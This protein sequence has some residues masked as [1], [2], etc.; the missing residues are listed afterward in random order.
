MQFEIIFQFNHMR[1]VWGQTLSV[2]KYGFT[3]IYQIMILQGV[4]T[5][6]ICIACIYIYIYIYIYTYAHIYILFG[7]HSNITI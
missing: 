6:Y 4:G 2:L 1:S 7:F 5:E 3:W